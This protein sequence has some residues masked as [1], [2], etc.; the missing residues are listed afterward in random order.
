MF[1]S[2]TF[3]DVVPV[4]SCASGGE[5]NGQSSVERDRLIGLFMQEVC[6]IR[7]V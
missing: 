1:V 4:G 2:L 3:D 6:D 5:E 7:P